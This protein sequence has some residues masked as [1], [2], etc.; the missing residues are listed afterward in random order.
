MKEHA[1]LVRRLAK[2]HDLPVPDLPVPDTTTPQDMEEDGED[3]ECGCCFS[4]YPFVSKF[5]P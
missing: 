1:W 3:I 2:H 5:V 4:S